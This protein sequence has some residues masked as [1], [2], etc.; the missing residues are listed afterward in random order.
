MRSLL[1][2]AIG[3]FAV[4]GTAAAQQ[5]QYQPARYPAPSPAAAAA[6]PLQPASGTTVISGGAGCSNCG[7]TTGPVRGFVMSGVSAPGCQLGAP[8]NSGCGSIKSDLAFQFG[9]CKNFFSPCGPTWGGFGHKCPTGPMNQPW[10]TG[11]GCPRAYDSH[12]NH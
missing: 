8:C 2:A 6:T 11:Y 10:G 12:A 3:A 9:S 7:T 4:S 1:L 5:P